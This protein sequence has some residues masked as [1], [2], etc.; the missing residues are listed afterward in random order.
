LRA[1]DI[2]DARA[3]LSVKAL[4]Q[5]DPAQQTAL[6][7]LLER[8]PK[9]RLIASSTK[10]LHPLR[11]AGL[12]DDLFFLLDA[13]QIEVPSLAQRKKDLGVL[14]ETLVRQTVR[15]M[16]RD[17]PMI[18]DA[19]YAQVT[20]RSWPDN[21]PELRNFARSFALGLTL[22]KSSAAELTLAEQIAA[23]ET[24][25]LT[26]TLR[27]FG[28]KSTQVADALGLP[29]KTLYDKLAKHGLRPKDFRQS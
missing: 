28:G 1:L 14:F 5:A 12:S 26:D 8:H 22:Q 17:M 9:M 13:F 4:D 25:V 10:G 3:D 6:L 18:P 11:A 7:D 16:N 19:L 23:F 21:L 2:P 27:R 15:G 29:R 24:L 20:A